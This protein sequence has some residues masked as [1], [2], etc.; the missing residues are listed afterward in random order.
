MKRAVTIL[1]LAA[2]ALAP[3]SALAAGD[4][5]RSAEDLAIDQ[6]VAE[7][8]KDALSPPAPLPVKHDKPLVTA[9]PPEGLGLGTKLGL[10][11][12]VGGAAFWLVRSRLAARGERNGA[13]KQGDKPRVLSR[14]AI[15]LR[16]EVVVIEV[17]GQRFLLGVAPGS[18]ASLGLLPDEPVFA[19]AAPER[20]SDFDD[21]RDRESGPGRFDADERRAVPLSESLSRLI[22]AARSETATPRAPVRPLISSSVQPRTRPQAQPRADVDVDE[23]GPTRPNRAPAQPRKRAP[24]PAATANDTAPEGQVRGLHARRSAP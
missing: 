13:S 21:L 12:L 6:A 11:A 10:C 20:D 9:P 1:A 4:E 5:E 19:S 24:R 7:A 8:E 3:L 18:I 16:H 22:A 15:G 2:S 17:E 23:L 14:T